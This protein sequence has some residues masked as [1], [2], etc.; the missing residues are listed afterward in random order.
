M[1]G[2]PRW[3][4]GHVTH[5][6]HLVSAEVGI[7]VASAGWGRGSGP[8]KQRA[9]LRQSLHSKDEDGV[10]SYLKWSRRAGTELRGAAG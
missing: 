7:G 10:F 3:A 8:S 2:S 1:K 4:V 5:T 9:Q 6:W